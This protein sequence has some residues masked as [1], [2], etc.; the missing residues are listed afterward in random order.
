[1]KLEFD[2]KT[3]TNA[4]SVVGS[5]IPTRSP[6]P[7]L[8]NVMIRVNTGNVTIIGTDTDQAIRYEIP[9]VEILGTKD[10]DVLLPARRLSEILREVREEKVMF[11][12]LKDAVRIVCGR[13]EFRLPLTD[14]A[15]YP[16]VAA[17][18]DSAYFKIAGKALREMIR[19]T[20]FAT[21][22]ESSRYALGGILFEIAQDKL[23]FVTTDSR[24]L[25][26]V[27]APLTKEGKAAAPTVS[28]VVPARA[29]SLVEKTTGDSDEVHIAIHQGNDALF[30]VGHAT[31]YSRLLEGRFP[32][33]QDVIPKTH[34]MS[35]ELLA[36]QFLQVVRQA[37]ILTNEESCGVDF[38][39]SEGTLLLTSQAADIGTS[40]VEMPIGHSG[41]KLII[42]FD[43]RYL[44]DFLKVLA[45]ETQVS[46]KLSTEEDPGLLC[47]EDGYSY[48]IMPLSRES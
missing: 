19:R 13:S 36:G 15:E 24:R 9:D 14:P 34:E 8:Q 29:M 25:A 42:R 46:F 10:A 2:R 21:D 48:V 45:P 3:L 47:T 20:L 23:S 28:P 32:R 38:E 18:T 41:A 6:K 5:V 26:M 22:Q 44:V 39:F 27:H 37:Q 4:I 40:R 11:E 17:F 35:I 33:Y 43:P 30:K 1:M 12:V 7:I 16:P 31:I